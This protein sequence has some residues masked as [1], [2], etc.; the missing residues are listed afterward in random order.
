MLILIILL[1]TGYSV[2]FCFH[3]HFWFGMNGWMDEYFRLARVKFW[4][5]D[6]GDGERCRCRW[7]GGEMQV[8]RVSMICLFGFECK[9]ENI[10]HCTILLTTRF[11]D[12]SN[13][14]GVQRKE[15]QSVVI[16]LYVI[17]I[18][19]LLFYFIYLNSSCKSELSSEYVYLS[20]FSR[21]L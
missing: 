2:S 10:N 9:F 21:C 4:D 18:V 15:S 16:V 19:L 13:Q 11:G 17:G 1:Y 20:L 6:G 12:K 3:F 7:R 8:G 5:G 14:N